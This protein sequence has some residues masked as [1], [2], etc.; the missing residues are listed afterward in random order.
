MNKGFILAMLI[1]VI[2]IGKTK[3]QSFSTFADSICRVYHLPGMVYAAVNSDSVITMQAHNYSYSRSSTK[4]ELNDRFHIGSN[5]KAVTAFVATMLIKEGK[6]NADTKFFDLFPELKKKSNK[7]YFDITLEKLLTYRTPLQKYT[8]TNKKP[9]AK[10][11]GNGEDARYLLAKYF[12]Q[13]KPF[14]TA[15]GYHPS[16]LN[17]V[18]A[19]LMLEKA[20]G[21]SY[22]ELVTDFGK[23]I[24]VDWNFGVPNATTGTIFDFD[25]YKL[26]WLLS[27]GNINISLPQYVKFMQVLLKGL[28]GESTLLP[29][30]SFENL[31]FGLPNFS[32][33][34]F[35]FTD[36]RGHLIATNTGNAG[37][38][39]SMVN[40]DKATGKGYVIFTTAYGTDAVTGLNMLMEKM[41]GSY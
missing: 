18:L 1:C 38:F 7:A 29:K 23:T 5:T 8:Y 14:I 4:I 13:Q 33:G 36:S 3:G 25:A 30:E 37:T 27:A 41:M 39:T 19:G 22:K 16:N 12:L 21:K 40:I 2:T 15:D 6:I 31:L 32:Y 20:T 11:I 9:A 24:G 35:N 10:Q 17:Y 26:D 28:K 34:W